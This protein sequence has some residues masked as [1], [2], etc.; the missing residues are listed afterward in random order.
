MRSLLYTLSMLGTLAMSLA[1]SYTVRAQHKPSAS[2]Q[3][4]AQ[5]SDNYAKDWL[6]EEENGFIQIVRLRLHVPFSVS[7]GQLAVCPINSKMIP[8][9]EELYLISS[10]PPRL[11]SYYPSS[12][13]NAHWARSLFEVKT[14]NDLRG[15]VRI[16]TP[17][18]ALA[19]VRLP[20][21]P[22]R[23]EVE[24]VSQDTVTPEFMFGDQR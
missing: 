21:S 10:T 20:V 18:Q 22:P 13:R 9:K 11:P 7:K 14:L 6:K 5:S 2:K 4:K 24:V 19:Y 12:W 1:V 23:P 16:L 3:N 17:Q 15:Y 8:V